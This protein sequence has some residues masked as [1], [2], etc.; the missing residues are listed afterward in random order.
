MT[1][2]DARE[3]F[4]DWTDDAL[5]VE[6]RARVEAHLGQC[7]DCRKELERFTAT[8]ALLHR[9]ERPRAPVGFVDRVLA[10]TQSVPWYGRLFQRLFLP[11][12]VKLPA[13]AAALL[14]VAGLAVYVFQRTPE[15]Q[16]T[17]QETL[18]PASRPAAPTLPPASAPAGEKAPRSALR[19][20][21]GETGTEARSKFAV[22]RQDTGRSAPSE[23]AKTAPQSAPPAGAGAP[24]PGGESK[25]ERRVQPNVE[26]RK[27]TDLQG[28]A[29][30]TAPGP[31]AS[32]DLPG[33]VEQATKAGKPAAPAAGGAA[34]TLL[35]EPGVE[36]KK[37]AKARS[38]AAPP[39]PQ[40]APS[41][42]RPAPAQER[43]A[44]SRRDEL[45]RSPAREA[46]SSA[47]AARVLPSGNVVGRLTVKDRFAAEQALGAL[48]TRSGGVVI[49][50]RDDAGTTLVEVAVPRT[51]YPEFSQGLTRLGT[52]R[53][54]GEPSELPPDVRVTLR[55]VE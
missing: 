24:S 22:S 16:R 17:A 35:A 55:L 27:E 31:P 8:V 15:L 3:L 26:F 45:V 48:L 2:H 47:S 25:V 40:P 19:D 9:T 11:L 21:S 1:C 53:P 49:S 5:T 51:A 38:L 29:T 6:Q 30:P 41:E 32:R 18:P 28:A 39:A 20:R 52:W 36:A 7:A 14:L 12:S 33:I 50:R 44:D 23:L 43:H 54:E 34:P 4:S 10:A 42:A 13:E 37:E 46:P